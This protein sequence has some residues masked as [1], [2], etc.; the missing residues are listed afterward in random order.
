MVLFI[1]QLNIK[2]MPY[3]EKIIFYMKSGRRISF[4]A[5]KIDITRLSGSQGNRSFKYESKKYF[6]ID[7]KEI[8]SFEIKRT[9][10]GLLFK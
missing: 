3:K 9:F 10:Y 6:S 8:E 7:L 1:K 5:N 4:K 2:I